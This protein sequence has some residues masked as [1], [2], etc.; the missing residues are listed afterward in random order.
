[1]SKITFT[2]KQITVLSQNKYIKKISIKAITYTFDFKEHFVKEIELG[3]SARSIFEEAGLP[4]DILGIKRIQT[5]RSRWVKAYYESDKLGLEDSRSRNN[6]RPL[7]RE[8]TDK[9][10]LE[11]LK[12]ELAYANGVIEYLKKLD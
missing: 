2:E 10:Q 6:G 12:A 5:A 3:K 8:L 7:K 1:M 4:V 9:E 11:K